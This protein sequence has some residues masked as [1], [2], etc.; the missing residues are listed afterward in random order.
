VIGKCFVTPSISKRTSLML[1][2]QMPNLHQQIRHRE[3][4]RSGRWRGRRRYE[5]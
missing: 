5:T 3:N 4:P 2:P 1:P